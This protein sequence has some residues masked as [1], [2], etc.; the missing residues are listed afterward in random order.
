MGYIRIPIVTD[1]TL[2]SQQAFS[3][4]TNLAPQWVPA[5]GN[6]DVWILRAVTALAAENRDIASDVQDDIFRYFGATLVGIAPHNAT[7][8]Q[9]T[10]TWVMND[11]AGHIIPVGTTVGIRDPFGNLQAFVTV[12]DVTVPNGSSATAA[13]EV[14]IVALQSGSQANG[15]GTAG[16]PVELID[17]LDWVQSITLIATTVG[18]G[19]AEFDADYLAR[20]GTTLQH[21]SQ[22]PILP[23]DF[24][25]L[26]MQADPT[27]ARAI[28]IDGYNPGDS[29]YNNMRMMAVAAVDA[30]GNAVS[31]PIKAKIDAL[32]Q[33]NRE[34]NFV[35]S[36]IDPKYTT[37]NVVTTIRIQAGFDG[38]ATDS[39]VTAAINNFLSPAYWG[40]SPQATQSESA[41]TW[42][43]TP[44]VFFNDM[45]AVI[46]NVQGVD[47][48]I[49]LTLNAGT[50]DITLATPAALT[51][52]GTIA[53]SHA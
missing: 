16:G 27:I 2:L 22:R 14:S 53:I 20:L 12:N 28:G 3:Y 43:E 15:I 30:G 33:A 34:V 42:L 39:A 10:T 36:V 4:I 9:G 7:P 52:P 8:A 1:P 50:A 40:I 25:W 32:L 19:D 11:N 51:R 18:G 49:S 35:V 31:A 48:V 29:T 26:A 5:E 38:S 37:I 24:S 23:D 47:H 6:L 13:G 21:L 44:T 41:Y 46:T 45:V 17:V